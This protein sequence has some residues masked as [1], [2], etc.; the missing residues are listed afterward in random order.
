MKKAANAAGRKR[1]IALLSKRKRTA[2]GKEGAKAARNRW[3]E[4][5]GQAFIAANAMSLRVSATYFRPPFLPPLRE[6][7]LLRFFPRP[8]PPFFRPPLS[9]LFTV[10][11]ARLSASLLLTPRFL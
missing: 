2:L 7:D 3:R 10:A 9:D 6:L 11:H 5:S 8:P 1:T 4:R